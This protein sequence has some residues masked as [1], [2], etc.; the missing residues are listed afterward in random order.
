M[1]DNDIT[2]PRAA[3][4]ADVAAELK[5][6]FRRNGHVRR[7]RPQ[8][9][10]HSEY[11]PYKKGEEVRLM[12]EDEQ[13]LLC[14]QDLLQRAGFRPGRPFE[15]RCHYCLPLYGRKEVQRFL[16]LIGEDGEKEPVEPDEVP[17]GVAAALARRSGRSRK[18]T[19]AGAG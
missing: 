6:Y 7:Q 9:L 8:R 2:R 5:F 16:D 1:R 18:R 17:K 12:A 15:K 3:S 11:W 4:A 13:E 19:D 10:E 14:I